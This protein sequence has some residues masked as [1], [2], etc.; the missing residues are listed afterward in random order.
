MSTRRLF[1]HGSSLYVSVIILA[2]IAYL[3]AN[4]Y[5]YLSWN[6]LKFL[7]L[8]LLILSFFFIAGISLKSTVFASLALLPNLNSYIP[9]PGFSITLTELFMFFSICIFF[10][11]QGKIRVTKFVL[12]SAFLILACILSLVGSPLGFLSVGMLIRL[13]ILLIF[14]SIL[15]G[16]SPEKKLFDPVFYGILTIPVIACA[17]YSGEGLLLIMFTANVFGFSRVIYSFQY[18]IWFSLLIPLLLYVKMPKIVIIFFSVFV[19]YLIVLS[20]ARSIIVGTFFSSLMFIFFM[21][22]KNAVKLAFAKTFTILMFAVII[23]IVTI[24]LGFFE[25]TSSESGSNIARYDK[26]ELAINN[27]IKHPFF[28]SGFG[29]SNDQAFAEKLSV[30]EV[31]NDVISP[32]F[33]PLTVLAEIGIVGGFFLVALI[34]ISFIHSVR[35]LR[36]K[37][38]AM[39]Y[40]ILIFIT[41]GGFVSSFLN[42]NSTA[43]II[44]YT[45][46][47]IPVLIYKKQQFVLNPGNNFLIKNGLT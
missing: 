15:V 4:S 40:K 36:D 24:A 14:T 3:T 46:L 44:V 13:S 33:G 7:L 19:G 35:C 2:F 47:A 30:S 31:F 12:F 32:E 29:A 42:S 18:P 21:K 37:E 26:M 34:Y 8:C 10:V 28:G 23:F 45:F 20:F 27:I 17:T 22:S 11:K 38:L 25:F 43:S 41:F 6:A 9:F 5:Y 16:S 1:L 39:H